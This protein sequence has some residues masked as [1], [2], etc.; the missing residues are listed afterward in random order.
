MD[1]IKIN[2]TYAS[3]VKELDSIFPGTAKKVKSLTDKKMKEITKLALQA[4]Q[5]KVPQYTKQLRNTQ[6]K[7]EIAS[8]FGDIKA[9]VFVT[10]DVHTNTSGRRK[11]TASSLAQLL[12]EGVDNG[13][14]LHRRKGALSANSLFSPPSKGSLT[15]GWIG[16]ANGDFRSV[17]PGA[18]N[19]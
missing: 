15:A 13:V 1:L 17:L 2:L 10:D 4:C 11:P 7:S 6:I 19:G 8:N 5:S 12:D 9:R 16:H 18:L 14:V 3:S